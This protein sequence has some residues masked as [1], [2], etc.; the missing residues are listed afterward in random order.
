[1]PRPRKPLDVLEATGAV[2]KD[3]ARYRDRQHAPPSS[4]DGIGD[5]PERLSL[6]QQ[7]IWLEIVG[8]TEPG[9]LLSSDRLIL[10][11]V[12]RLQDKFQRNCI[13]AGE[14]AI[15]QSSLAKMGFSPVDRAKVQP[16]QRAKPVSRFAHL[17]L[18]NAKPTVMQ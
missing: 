17:G 9:A 16:P 11:M 3:P 18:L 7:A 2:R 4:L 6:E 14:L 12:C 10:E 1:M 5:P 8:N 13:R 15:L